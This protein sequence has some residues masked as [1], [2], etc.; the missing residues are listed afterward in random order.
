MKPRV[1]NDCIFLRHLVIN[2]VGRGDQFLHGGAV[3][4]HLHSGLSR[5][6]FSRRLHMAPPDLEAMEARS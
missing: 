2:Y 6:D 4:S 1:D 3:F 5:G